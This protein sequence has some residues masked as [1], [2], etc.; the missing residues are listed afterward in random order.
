MAIPNKTVLE[1]IDK[2]I[3]TVDD[4]YLFDKDTIV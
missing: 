3:R 4:L 1:L 2:V